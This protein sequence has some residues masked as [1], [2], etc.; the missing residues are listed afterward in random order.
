MTDAR[1]PRSARGLTL[2][3]MK[4]TAQIRATF[5]NRSIPAL[6]IKLATTL[7]DKFVLPSMPG[8]GF[9][10]KPTGTGWEPRPYRTSLGGADEA[11]RVYPLRCPGRQRIEC[12]LLV[13]LAVKWL[14]LGRN[15]ARL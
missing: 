4:S 14:V 7:S 13:I 12:F 10:R 9:S 2:G 15:R 5:S 1:Q 3:G 8:Y 6:R 11:P